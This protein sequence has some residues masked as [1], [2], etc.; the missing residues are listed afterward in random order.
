SARSLEPELHLEGAD[1]PRS[2]AVAPSF[3]HGAP[4]LLPAAQPAVGWGH[5]L[6]KWNPAKLLCDAP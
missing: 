3:V 4:A 1:A 2:V 5:C 6:L